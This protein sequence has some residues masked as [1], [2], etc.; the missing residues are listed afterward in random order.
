VVELV[1]VASP[2]VVELVLVVMVDNIVVD[3]VVVCFLRSRRPFFF[4][5]CLFKGFEEKI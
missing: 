3:F 4:K 5:L 1:V 2:L